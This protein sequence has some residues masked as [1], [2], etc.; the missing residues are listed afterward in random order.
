MKMLENNNS[1]IVFIRSVHFYDTN[2]TTPVKHRCV[3]FRS[4]AEYIC[5]FFQ[6]ENLFAEDIKT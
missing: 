5:S 6:S 3:A 1:D 4:S 2:I